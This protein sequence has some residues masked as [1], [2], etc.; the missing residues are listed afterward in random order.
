MKVNDPNLL[1][2]PGSGDDV[3][4]LVRSLR[5]LATDSPERKAHLEEIARS[6]ANGTYRVDA[7]ATAAA[8]LRTQSF[9]DSPS[10]AAIAAAR[11]AVRR[12][13]TALLSPSPNDV[14]HELAALEEVELVLRSAAPHKSIRLELEALRTEVREVAGMIGLASNSA[15][16]AG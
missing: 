5:A 11:A 15:K 9:P 6:V 4:E 16:A 2:S 7:Q 8:M 1:L 10:P 12:M 14:V 3:L 13:R